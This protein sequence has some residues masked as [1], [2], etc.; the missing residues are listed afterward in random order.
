MQRF[1]LVIIGSECSGKTTLASKLALEYNVP[2]LE[3]ASREYAKKRNGQLSYND[4]MPIAHEQNRREES[5]LGNKDFTIKILDTCL[6]ST[7]IYSEM[8]YGKFP[9]ELAELIEMERYKHFILCQPDPVWSDDGVRKM[10]Y[11]RSIMHKMFKDELRKRNAEFT[12]IGG[13][14]EE[15]L[16]QAI[17]VLNSIDNRKF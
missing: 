3:E 5:F 12:E 4:V 17:N 10:P 13:S 2:F 16:T 14:N 1:S 6:L 8:Y 11:P 9:K 7:L 15:R